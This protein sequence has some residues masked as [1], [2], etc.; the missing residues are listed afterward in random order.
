MW[1]C[2]AK[3]GLFAM[4]FNIP[5]KYSMF[6]SWFR[7]RI[8]NI[9]YYFLPFSNHTMYICVRNSYALACFPVFRFQWLLI[10]NMK[11]CKKRVESEYWTLNTEHDAT[12]KFIEFI[13]MIVFHGI[14]KIYFDP[15]TTLHIYTRNVKLWKDCAYIVLHATIFQKTFLSRMQN[16]KS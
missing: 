15:I 9:L 3:S 14:W 6:V 11:V 7:C 8:S 12:I 2:D 13:Q 16:A 4:E 10:P 5:I 1:K